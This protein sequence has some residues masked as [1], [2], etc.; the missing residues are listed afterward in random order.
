MTRG[1]GR[2]RGHRWHPRGLPTR[3]LR[4][5]YVR[6][7]ACVRMYAC[8]HVCV[9]HV[10]EASP[11]EPCVEEV[12]GAEIMVMVRGR[13]AGDVVRAKWCVSMHARTCVDRGGLILRRELPLDA[14]DGVGSLGGV[15]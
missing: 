8:V 4:R 14:E 13:Y 2:E 12:G 15:P 3:A 6:T 9:W 10:H 11:Q 7:C 5:M 1:R